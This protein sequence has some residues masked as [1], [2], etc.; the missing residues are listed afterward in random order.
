MFMR[1][2]LFLLLIAAS[3]QAQNKI[4]RKVLDIE[5]ARLQAQTKQDTVLLNEVL[6]DALIYTHS[7]GIIETKQQYVRNVANKTWDY[8]TVDIKE[9]KATQI[10]KDLVV[11]NG[12]G[13]F[14]LFNQGKYLT[15]RL[16]FTDVYRYSKKRW[17]LITWQ[18]SRLADQ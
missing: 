6:D 4:E 13:I 8:R 3:A 17:R 10:A 5:Q 16:A 1:C 11:V 2:V 15:L 7:S 9:L 18:S 14:V 12:K